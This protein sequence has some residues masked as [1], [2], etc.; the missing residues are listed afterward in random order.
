[1]KPDVTN[2]RGAHTKGYPMQFIVVR[3]EVE[4]ELTITCNEKNRKTTSSL[5]LQNRE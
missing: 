1:V 5:S 2:Q 4:T 3:I